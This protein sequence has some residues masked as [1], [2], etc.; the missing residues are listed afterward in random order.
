MF[1]LVCCVGLLIVMIEQYI[2]PTVIQLKG[3]KDSAKVVEVLLKLSI[4]SLGAWLLMFFG[5]FHLWLNILGELTYF[6]DRA[7]YKVIVCAPQE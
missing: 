7:F 5:L 1:E 3:N 2:A 6:A 4:P